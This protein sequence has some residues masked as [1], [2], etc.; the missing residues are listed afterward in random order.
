MSVE[1]QEIKGPSSS[2]FRNRMK[3]RT[4]HSERQGNDAKDHSKK[5]NGFQ[6]TFE[7]EKGLYERCIAI[8]NIERL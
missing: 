2:T 8:C 4:T 1:Q 6:N 5:M 3:L 7:G